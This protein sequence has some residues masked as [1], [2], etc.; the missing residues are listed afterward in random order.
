MMLTGRQNITELTV[1]LNVLARICSLL[2]FPFSIVYLRELGGQ[3]TS[4]KWQAF[5]FLPM[6]GFSLLIVSLV[7]FIG[8]D[9]TIAFMR[10]CTDFNSIPPEFDFRRFRLLVSINHQ[11]YKILCAVCFLLCIAE[12]L[13][14][15]LAFRKTSDDRPALHISLEREKLMKGACISHITF[16]ILSIIA[17]IGGAEYMS[18]HPGA[19]ST[20]ALLMGFAL[21]EFFLYAIGILNI[22]DRV[23]QVTPSVPVRESPGANPAKE[24]RP[25]S[26]RFREYILE[27]KPYLNPDFKIEDVVTRLGSNRSYVSKMIN[28]DYNNSFKGYINYLRIETAKT[29]LTESPDETLGSIASKA[30]F[31]SD[32]QMIKKF[33]E[34][35]GVSPRTWA[36]QQ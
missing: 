20:L 10:H 28:S 5:L 21:F 23:A 17:I 15:I 26:E 36:K 27:E 12:S 25:L 4:L 19:A 6:I 2:L 35:E 33:K 34:I 11:L 18:G 32:S 22:K 14:I 31:Y 3:Q 16:S 1:H 13:R 24:R 29:L 8:I 30:G 9:E 7:Y